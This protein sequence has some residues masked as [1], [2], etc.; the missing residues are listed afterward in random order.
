METQNRIVILHGRVDAG[1]RADEQ[2]VLEEVRQVSA[3]LAALGYEPVPLPVSLDLEAAARSLGELEPLM[4]FNIVESIEGQDRFLHLAPCLLDSLGLLYTGTGSQGMYLASNKLVAK[5]LLHQA[6]I[7][8]PVW[9]G[10]EQALASGPD[11][12]PPYIVKSVWDNASLG[13]E[14]IFDSREKLHD[15]LV[16]LASA[17]RLADR[18]AERYVEGREF[19]LSVLQS[20]SRAEVLPPAEMLFVDY[21]PEKPRIVG[22][23]AKW[24]PA[25]F[26]YNH[27][28]RRFDFSGEDRQLIA[29]LCELSL[30]CWDALGIGGY[31]RVDF[32]VDGRGTPWVLEVNPNPCLSADAGLFAAATRAGYS[33]EQLVRRILQPVLEKIS[34]SRRALGVGESVP[35]GTDGRQS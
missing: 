9:I 24:D 14:C 8:T 10:A 11:F 35:S 13:L 29:R 33:Y 19:N 1:A 15:H 32:R 5:R 3:A 30:A 21:P 17:T 16:D 2:D 4:V 27:T 25:S 31:A 6:G 20:D 18:F 12:D 34:L 28:V 7:D 26:E 23:A 22:Y